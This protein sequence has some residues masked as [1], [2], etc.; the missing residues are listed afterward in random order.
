M[1]TI[2][3]LFEEIPDHRIDRGKLHNLAEIVVMS[4]Y[5]LLCGATTW[6]DI[7]EIC[8]ERKDKKTVKSIARRALI[9]PSF[10]FDLIQK[11]GL[12]TD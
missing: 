12:V 9:N 8:E 2:I 7:Q 6:I 1:D 3:S 10:A 11:S 4:L 5:G